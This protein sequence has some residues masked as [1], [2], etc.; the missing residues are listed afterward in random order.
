MKRLVSFLLAGA[1]L[2]AMTGFAQATIGWAGQIWPVNN[3]SVTDNADVGVYLQ[4]WKSGVTDQAG[5]GAGISATLYYGPNGGPYT[6]VAMTYHGD[7]GSNDEYTANIPSS[8]LQ[9]VSEIWFY[10]D[11]YDETD[12]TTYSGCQDQ[13]GNNPPFKLVVTQ[14]LGQDVTV[15][16]FMCMPPEGDPEY[17]AEPGDICITGDHAEIT[18]WGSG[19]AMVQACPSFSP[20]LYQTSVLFHAGDNP[21]LQYKY[22]KQGCSV[23]EPGGNHSVFIDDSSPVFYVPWV[24]HWGYYDGPDCP[25]CGVGVE[26]TSWGGIKQIYR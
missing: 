8:A 21:A 4:I 20:R 14:T 12:M 15:Y 24:D 9:G 26:S 11:A 2:V 6:S 16:F 1:M 19:V 10:C 7:I 17:D 13:N 22:R 3:A 23:W 18:N 25:L 5:Q